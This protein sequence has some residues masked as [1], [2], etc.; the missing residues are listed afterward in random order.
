MPSLNEVVLTT[1]HYI[2]IKVNTILPTQA[3][4]TGEGGSL[5]CVCLQGYHA[6]LCNLSDL[7]LLF[8]ALMQVF[9][10]LSNGVAPTS[11]LYFALLACFGCESTELAGA[12]AE[13]LG[14]PR[15]CPLLSHSAGRVCLQ[16]GFFFFF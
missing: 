15:Q 11:S 3:A 6:N 8:Q 13:H 16:V 7:V 12:W 2:T 14:I 1:T 9:L 4:T 5:F 10:L